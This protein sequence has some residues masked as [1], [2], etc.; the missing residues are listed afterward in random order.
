MVNVSKASIITILS[1][2][3]FTYLVKNLRGEATTHKPTLKITT[4]RAV[5]RKILRTILCGVRKKRGQS[6]VLLIHV[7]SVPGTYTVETQSIF[8]F[9]ELKVIRLC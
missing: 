6:H 2:W 9:I 1:G 8:F 4:W 5:L 7:D 3:Y